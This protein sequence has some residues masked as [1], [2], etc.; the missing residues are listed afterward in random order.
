M[1]REGGREGREGGREGGRERGGRG[2]EG[3]KGEVWREGGREGY[4]YSLGSYL[5]NID[6]SYCT[7]VGRKGG[8]GGG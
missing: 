1:R 7:T 3:G 2:G 4:K 6:H 8:R 5:T